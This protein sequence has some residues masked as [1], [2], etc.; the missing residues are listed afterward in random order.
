MKNISIGNRRTKAVIFSGS[1]RSMR[2]ALEAAVSQNISLAYA[3]LR[4]ARLDNANLD[5][6]D[7]RHATLE[8]ATL[9]G[10]NLSEADFS[11]TN[12]R[13][14]DLTTTCL[15]ESRLVD[16]DFTNASF[17]AT[18]ITGAVIDNCIFTCA[19]ALGLPFAEA[20]AGRNIFELDGKVA[21]FSGPPLVLTGLPKRVAILDTMVM[22]GDRFYPRADMPANL[23]GDLRNLCLRAVS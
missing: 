2:E 7:F 21:L 5:G 6:G 15:C 20:R 13:G 18:L 10:A 1:F 9:A 19:S 14:A 23:M 4:R 16:T 22:I 11:H 17:A 8:G 12:L 3:D